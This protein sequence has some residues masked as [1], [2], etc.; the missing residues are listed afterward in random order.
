MANGI[1]LSD[2]RMI[3]A[4]YIVLVTSLVRNGA[5]SGFRIDLSNSQQVIVSGDESAAAQDYYKVCQ[6]IG[7]GR[8]V[9]NL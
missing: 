9:S 4:D 7:V 6:A 3:N 1:T 2:G 5:N 8:S